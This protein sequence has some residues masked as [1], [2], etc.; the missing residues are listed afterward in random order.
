MS[1]INSLSYKHIKVSILDR[2]KTDDFRFNPALL[3]HLA[4]G[5]NYGLLVDIDNTLNLI[6]ERIERGDE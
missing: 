5:F 3:R 1:P 4:K 2:L 6:T